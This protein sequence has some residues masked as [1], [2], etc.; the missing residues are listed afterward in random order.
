MGS[1]EETISLKDAIDE[2]A[3]IGGFLG[4][5]NEGPPGATVIWRGL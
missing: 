2:V 3:L 1:E 5:N 4:R